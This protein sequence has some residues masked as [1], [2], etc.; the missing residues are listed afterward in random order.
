MHPLSNICE[1]CVDCLQVKQKEKEKIGQLIS[2]NSPIIVKKR[3]WCFGTSFCHCFI[4][5]CSDRPV[6]FNS[7][8]RFFLVFNLTVTFYHRLNSKIIAVAWERF[9]LLP[10]K[11]VL[12]S[13]SCLCC[14]CRMCADD[15]AK[16]MK[17]N[18]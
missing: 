14:C 4:C 8:S 3:N 7:F 11:S 6:I 12:Y 15:F 1:M 16:G 13:Q 10:A 17:F 18:I 9:V 2:S 5:F